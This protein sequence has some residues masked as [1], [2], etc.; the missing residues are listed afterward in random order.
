MH[1]KCVTMKHLPILFILIS[2]IGFSCS[3]V[4][5]KIFNNQSPR[6]K[7]ESSIED[8]PEAQLW[9]SVSR[10]ALDQPQNIQLP[11][12]IR[13]HFQNDKARSLGL[14]FRARR[15]EQLNFI[16][17]KKPTSGVIYTD[18]FS[19]EA[20][21]ASD[22]LVTADTGSTQFSLDVESTGEYII[23]LQPELFT[24]GDYDLVITSGP[25]L[26]FPVSGNKAS[27]GSFWGASRDG[28]KRNHEGIDIFAPKR[29]PVVAAA[30]GMV[31]GVRE[32]GIG[33]KVIWMRPAG[34]DLSLYYAHLDE[35]LVHAGQRVK[36]GEILGLV[37]NTGNARTTPAHLHFGIY[38]Y[39]GAIDPLDFVQ[40]D[41]KKIPVLPEKTIAGKQLKL[42]KT[43]KAGDVV[44]KANA[45]LDPVG[46]TSKGYIAELPGGIKMLVPFSEAR[47]IGKS[48]VNSMAGK[49]VIETNG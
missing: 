6:E 35:Q 42:L 3:S 23:R 18:V 16:F 44:I 10:S 11:F 7:Y 34:K 20:V 1:L 40:E 9:L 38:T 47:A 14:R 19:A 39:G 24:E 46:I 27:I 33:G 36:K 12:S 25:S 45:F 21:F 4:A 49:T 32:G 37:G 8:S 43:Q 29:T 2:V 30:D 28:G 22:P 13:G 41:R 15:G 31:T 17:N 5:H 48:S 26:G